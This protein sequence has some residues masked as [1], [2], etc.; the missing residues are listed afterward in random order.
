MEIGGQS[1]V[2][3]TDPDSRAMPTS[4]KADVGYNVQVAVDD[5]HK[6]FVVQEVTK[7]VTGVD[8]LS[9]LALQAKEALE[10]EQVKVVADMGCYHGE[11]L[12]A[13]E[14]AGIE[15]Y[16]AKPLTSANRK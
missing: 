8:Q 3:L 16:V 10:V 15:P 7:A 4:S 9:G 12:R 13:C 14:E 2:S 5:K 6:L 11:E 1:Q